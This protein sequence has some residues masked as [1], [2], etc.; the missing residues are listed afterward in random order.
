M[1]FFTTLNWIWIAVALVTFLVLV[2]FKIRVP[3]GRHTVKGW[4]KLINNHW[5]WFLMEIPA[6]LI[7]PIIAI[8]GPREKSVLSWILISL[9]LLHYINRTLIFP[10]RIKTKGK[11]MP[12]SIL[13]SAIFFNG[14]NG[15]LNGYYLGVYAPTD[16]DWQSLHVIIGIAIFAIGFIINNITDSKLI[17]LRKTGAG[18]QI[19]RKWLFKYISCPNHFGE[20]IEWTGF[21]IVA[22]SL[23]AATFAI[24]TFCNLAPRALNHHAWYQENFPDYPRKRKAFLPFIW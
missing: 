7:F 22:W 8:F 17:A 23:P 10:F 18:Y 12:L 9:W 14:M 19:P 13:L 1:D 2:L 24:W 11:K 15:F 16:D 6:L 5:A 3:Y 4:G 21:A 20:I